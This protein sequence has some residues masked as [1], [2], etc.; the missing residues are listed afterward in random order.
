MNINENEDLEV[1]NNE[2]QNEVQQTSSDFKASRKE[3]AKKIQERL[4][5]SSIKNASKQTVL[6]AL[7]PIITYVA[8]FIIAVIIIIGIAMFFITMTGMAIEK[9]KWLANTVVNAV[10][11]W[12]GADTTK[13]FED[14][15][16][17]ESLE[18]LEQ[19]GYDL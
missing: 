4:S 15:E 6:R 3:T 10:D 7:M 14:V 13:Q 17:Y 11:S 9:I 18:Y 5:K 19:M 1:S 8:L 16:I 12:F 2:N